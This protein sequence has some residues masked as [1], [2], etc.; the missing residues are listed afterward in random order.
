MP[1]TEPTTLPLDRIWYLSGCGPEAGS[2]QWN[3]TELVV[4]GPALSAVGRSSGGVRHGA[5][6]STPAAI[7]R[8]TTAA[9]A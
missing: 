4:A 5:Q 7:A 2:D 3:I 1:G 8:T 9:A 6:I